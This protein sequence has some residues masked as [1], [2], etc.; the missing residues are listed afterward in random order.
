M[1][2]LKDR[3]LHRL[4]EIRARRPLL[5]QLVRMQEHY[6]AVTAAQQAG[7]MTYFAFLSF[8][9]LLAVAVFF[10][11]LFA[12]VYPDAQDT[13]TDAIEQVIP[14][15]VGTGEGKI[16]LDDVQHFSGLAGLLGL[17]GVVYTG[18]GWIAAVREALEVVFEEPKSQ[19]PGFVAAKTRD[20]T[21]LV[22][23]GATLFVSVVAAGLVT[24]FSHDVLSWV[25]F[26]DELSWLLYVLT[27]LVG[28]AVNTLLFF[29]VFKLVARPQ[30]PS[31]ALWRGAVLGGIA[32]EV[33]KAISFLVLTMAQGNPAFQAFGVALV[34]VVWMNYTSRVILYAA[35]F[36]HVAP[37]ARAAR[38]ARLV[39][40][41]VQ[42]PQTPPLAVTGGPGVAQA[43]PDGRRTVPVGSFLAG[44]G[45]MVAALGLLKKVGRK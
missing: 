21:S 9:P 27:R 31:R 3:T 1:T 16:S 19:Q 23:I 38:A 34:L 44:A 12:N 45:T 25:G 11:G 40:P 33:L 41:P 29:L 35:S 42:G 20:L 5:D 17:L 8:F 4:H 22:V 13:L 24:G 15:L 36:A 14:G 28:L 32:F 43:S 39:A 7:A 2:G 30:T 18:L 6:G 26:G 37:E 10:V